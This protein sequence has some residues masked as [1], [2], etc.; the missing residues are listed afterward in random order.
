MVDR[1]LSEE[2][3]F[4]YIDEVEAYK[5]DTSTLALCSPP[6]YRSLNPNK[7]VTYVRNSLT[8]NA[9]NEFLE[10]ATDPVSWMCALDVLV[11]SHK[12]PRLYINMDRPHNYIRSVL[13]EAYCFPIVTCDDS[14]AMSFQTT[15]CVASELMDS[16]SGMIVTRWAKA[17][18]LEQL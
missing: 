7:E 5:K 2:Q 15:L 13:Y 12:T 3:R 14:D 10:L 6:S 16:L 8:M 1:S 9:I 18:N 17:P 4:N 11:T